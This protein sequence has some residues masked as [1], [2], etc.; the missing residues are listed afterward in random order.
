MA[1]RNPA[2]INSPSPRSGAMADNND[3]FEAGLDGLKETLT[4]MGGKAELAIDLAVRFYLTHDVRLRSE[5]QSIESQLT[6]CERHIDEIAIRL[7][8]HP[9]D[10]SNLRELSGYLKINTTL[11]YI[12][13]T[14]L[15]IGDQM[16]F[17]CQPQVLFPDNIREIGHATSEMIRRA[18]SARCEARGETACAV[19]DLG[20]FV[21]RLSDET[22]VYLVAQMRESPESFQSVLDALLL[23]RHLEQI[24][25]YAANMARDILL[26]IR[27]DHASLKVI[28]YAVGEV[29]P[30]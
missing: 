7:H 19:R 20:D 15:R 1:T 6:R 16:Q 9:L 13:Q 8:S 3:C 21:K 27:E 10:A 28:P 29:W 23:T 14:A 25:G 24:A 12:G 5:L 2:L 26:W 11:K 4:S 17:D 22:W 18:V 30:L